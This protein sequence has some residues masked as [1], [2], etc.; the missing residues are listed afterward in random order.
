MSSATLVYLGDPSRLTSGLLASPYP[1]DPWQVQPAPDTGAAVTALAHGSVDV[2]LID[3]A[4]VSREAVSALE[5]VRSEAKA[6]AVPVV[7]LGPA[8]DEPFASAICL[9]P[10]GSGWLTE[11]ARVVEQA[12]IDRQL[13]QLREIGGNE[14]VTEMIGM[15]LQQTPGLLRTLRAG[16]EANDLRAVQREAHSL[17]SSAGNFGA[18]VVQELAF[19]IERAAGDGN[20]GPLPELVGQLEQAYERV[21]ALLEARQH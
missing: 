12:R 3:P 19:A 5:R 15:F 16:L 6:H 4:A 17:K 20:A 18:R 8:A 13:A 2:L 11:L 9:P 7:V 14:F 10:A 21:K 1:G